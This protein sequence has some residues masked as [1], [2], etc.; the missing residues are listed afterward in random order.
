MSKKYTLVYTA[1]DGKRSSIDGTPDDLLELIFFDKR[2]GEVLSL[3]KSLLSPV[4]TGYMDTW[5]FLVEH[6]NHFLLGIYDLEKKTCNLPIR[7]G[8]LRDLQKFIFNNPLDSKKSYSLELY[9]VHNR[10]IRVSLCSTNKLITQ[11][12]EGT[13]DYGSTS[14]PKELNEVDYKELYI[15][16]EIQSIERDIRNGLCDEAISRIRTLVTNI[17]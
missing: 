14:V 12:V 9:C 13:W 7:C 4:A 15:E 17:K 2:A 5:K 3:S 1:L 6:C 8:K 11:I 10:D 16:S